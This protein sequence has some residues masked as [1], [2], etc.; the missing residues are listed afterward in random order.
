V[1]SD[2]LG[3]GRP[4]VMLCVPETSATRA[5][6]S[7]GA[8]AAFAVKKM[9]DDEIARPIATLRQPTPAS[10]SGINGSVLASP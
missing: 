9:G 1:A 5:A 8:G 10:Q 7:G 3:S 2:E 4:T 6:A